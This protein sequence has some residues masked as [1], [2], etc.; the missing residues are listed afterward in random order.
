MD[1]GEQPTF[2]DVMS[3]LNML[4]EHNVEFNILTTVHAANAQYPLEV[5]RFLRDEIQAKYLQFIPI[6]ERD[7]NTGFQEGTRVTSRSV[8]GTQYGNFLIEIF[9][10][11]VLQ[12]VGEI[13]IQLFDIALNVWAGLPSSLCVFSKTCGLALA[14]EHNGDIYSCDH[15]VE[16]SY[17]IGNIQ[18]QPLKDMVASHQQRQFGVSKN[19]SLPRYCQECEV[20]FICNG[21]CPKNRISKTPSGE[22]G[23]NYLCAG[24]KAFFNHINHPMNLMVDLL[25]AGQA[26]ADVMGML[27]N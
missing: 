9:D 24:Y 13:F 21:G 6:V 25:R 19:S 8:T 14:M 17:L 15:Y 22:Y 10:E 16:P 23:L 27:N 11:W 3:G 26:P 2:D 18:T 20:R 5:Y 4:K 1:K 7:N 12:D